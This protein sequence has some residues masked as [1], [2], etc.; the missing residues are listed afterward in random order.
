MRMKQ[1]EGMG[2]VNFWCFSRNAGSVPFFI[3]F[4][5]AFKKIFQ[6]KKK[7]NQLNLSANSLP[8]RRLLI[9]PVEVVCQ[10][11]LSEK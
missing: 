6:E 4:F 11:D 1:S 8:I 3:F 2:H 9:P 10:F 7:K 5:V